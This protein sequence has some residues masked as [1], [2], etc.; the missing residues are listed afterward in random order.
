MTSDLQL[1]LHYLSIDHRH[2]GEYFMVLTVEGQE[3][4]WPI[5]T[6]FSLMGCVGSDKL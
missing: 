1:K 5:L 6:E 4:I 2:T 3:Q